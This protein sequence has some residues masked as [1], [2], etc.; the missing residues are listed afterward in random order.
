MANEIRG[1]GPSGRTMYAHI[2]NG[3]GQRWNGSAFE[4][5]AS[6]NYA[7]YDIALTENGTSGVYV[8]TF[9]TTI[10]TAGFYEYFY[11]IQAGGSPAEGDKVSGTGRVDWSGSVQVTAP[12]GSMS[13]DDFRDYVVR[14][15]IRT[16]KDTEL[17]EAVTDTVMELRERYHFDDDEVETTTTD[18]IATLG[19]Y[20]LD[21]ETNFGILIGDIVV[22]DGT[23]S[24]PIHQISK[25]KYDRLYPNPAATN[26]TTAKPRHFC[27]FD[28]QIYL[29]PVPDSTSY[30][31]RVNYSIIGATITAATTS[32]PFTEK[33]RETLKLGVLYRLYR[34]L[35]NFDLATS[36]KQLY[37]SSVTE[38]ILFEERNKA[39][40][41]QVTYRGL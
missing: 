5:Y 11:Y 32:V 4:T 19:E 24:W 36:Y 40:S 38:K 9:P 29:G 39:G 15:F 16:D 37:D 7:N 6:A 25:Q 20:K 31:Y 34:D 8:G 10:T 18:T 3:S 21:L 22:I 35:E 26:V 23:D 13:A 12:A 27:L 30:T 28:D 14:T 41:S 33:Y 2:V 17:Y 1:I